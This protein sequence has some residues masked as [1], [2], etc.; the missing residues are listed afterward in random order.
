MLAFLLCTL[1]IHRKYI[2]EAIQLYQKHI[3]DCWLDK[4]TFYPPCCPSK[5]ILFENALE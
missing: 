4:M 2:P 1:K 3:V 5:N